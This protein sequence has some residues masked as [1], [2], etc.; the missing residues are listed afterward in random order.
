MD[1]FLVESRLSLL[2]A[3]VLNL[4][5]LKTGLVLQ[6]FDLS[7]PLFKSNHILQMLTGITWLT[8]IINGSLHFYFWLNVEN[9]PEKEV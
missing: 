2:D 7:L 9:C 6:F 5:N 8:Y 3:S 1:C 4:D